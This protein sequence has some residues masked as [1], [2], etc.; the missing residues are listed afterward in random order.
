[1]FRMK[2]CPTFKL[3]LKFEPNPSNGFAVN[4]FLV[5]RQKEV[6]TIEK[7]V[8]KTICCKQ[9][10]QHNNEKILKIRIQQNLYSANGQMLSQC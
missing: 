6:R 10:L 5:K 2:D 1:M 8:C 7:K 4:P 9:K 3:Y